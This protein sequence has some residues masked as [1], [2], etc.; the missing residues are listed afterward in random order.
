[1]DKAYNL[2]W[3][4]E[5]TTD[6]PVDSAKWTCELGHG[7]RGWGNAESQEYRD[8]LEHCRVENGRL[9]IT[10]TKSEQSE[11]YGSARIHTYG[12]SSWQYGRFEIRAKLPTGRGT[13]PA[14]WM[15]SDAH[16]EGTPWPLCGEIDIM[17]HVGR[18]PEVIH[19]SLHTQEFNH[20]KKTQITGYHTMSGILEG[21]HTYRMDWTPEGFEFFVDGKLF[22][23][24]LKA[25]KSTIEEWPFDQPFHLIV[26]LAIG[27]H[28]G[29]EIDDSVLPATLELEYI[30]VYQLD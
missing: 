25:G 12:K 14:L 17:E 2:V 5:F 24:F 18:N 1:M 20:P 27:G 8:D 21:F 6:G 19:F 7:I 9:I 10:G 13:W 23:S 11:T 22:N 26:N 29:G 3:A 15:L 16:K 4:D 30:R 28:W